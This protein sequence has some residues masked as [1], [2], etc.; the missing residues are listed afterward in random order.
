MILCCDEG[1]SVTT[2]LS[3]LVVALLGVLTPGLDTMLVLR[4]ALL[5][6]RRAG[7][8]A[9]LGIT[10]G[11]LTWG[12]ASVLGLTAVLTA[13]TVAYTVVRILGAAY[14]FWLGAVA[15]WRTLPRARRRTITSPERVDGSAAPASGWA[16]LRAGLLTNLLNPKVGVFYISLLPQFLPAGGP[17]LGWGALLV[18]I[19]LTVGLLWMP[20]LVWMAGRARRLFAREPV[21]R[22]MER[23]TATV[24]IGLGVKLAAGSV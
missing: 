10:V 11:C 3:F 16:A 17:S 21:R 24:L 7:L 18:G 12:T 9:V 6:G 5:G 4:T 15:L 14:L 8:M 22:W 19:H 13:S 2:V 1:M 23:V 20:S